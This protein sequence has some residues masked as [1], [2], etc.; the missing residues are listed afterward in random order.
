M[1]N[2]DKGRNFRQFIDEN[3]IRAKSEAPKGY[4]PE[5]PDSISIYC[6]TWNVNCQNPEDSL[7][8]SQWL[9]DKNCKHIPDVYAIGFQEVDSNVSN[10]L[11]GRSSKSK[12]ER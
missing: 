9:L 3:R 5:G 6:A 11:H 2:I 10:L 1:D 12:A 7:D 8:L 4:N